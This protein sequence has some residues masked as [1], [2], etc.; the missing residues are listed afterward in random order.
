MKMV[1]RQYAEAAVQRD[2][3]LFCAGGKAAKSRRPCR[4]SVSVTMV[5]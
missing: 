1:C 3:L 5:A 2:C 4:G